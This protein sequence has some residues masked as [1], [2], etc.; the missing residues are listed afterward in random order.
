MQGVQ[1]MKVVLA[2]HCGEWE[3]EYRREEA[4][5]R[6]AMG[7]NILD[8]RHVGSTSIRTICAKPIL[9]IAVLLKDY[10]A[11]EIPKMEE[12]GYRYMGPRNDEDSRRLFVRYVERGAEKEIALA[13]VHCY[14]IEAQEDFELLVGFR[15]YL[16]AH[17]EDA[18]RY[19]LIKRRLAGEYS[20]DRF[21]YSDGKRAFIEEIN[22]KIREETMQ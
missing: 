1:R 14:R 21:A 5:I 20:D 9:D 10:E 17:P 19:D 16:N 22:R 2:E 8:I 6:G 4:Q 18:R 3:T 12:I 15:D 11:M 7:P 13:H